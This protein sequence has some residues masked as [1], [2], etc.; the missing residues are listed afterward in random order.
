MTR[1]Y[2]FW[3]LVSRAED[4]P[5]EWV[6]HCL[7]LDVVSQGRSLDHSLEAL[8]EAVT[9]VLADDLSENLDPYA[10]R[11]KAPTEDWD[12]LAQIA[13]KGRPLAN[14]EDV[15]QVRAAAL[16]LQLTLSEES[17]DPHIPKP[18]EITALEALRAAQL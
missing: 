8:A 6:A 15:G 3:V 18:W 7:D 9:M 12:R 2:S 11:A 16:Q 17:A 10:V 4:V 5:G 13:R 14:V 1:E